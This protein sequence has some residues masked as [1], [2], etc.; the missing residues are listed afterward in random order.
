MPDSPEILPA[1][2]RTELADLGKRVETLGRWLQELAEGGESPWRG[3]SPLPP[4]VLTRCAL[5]DLRQMLA[6]SAWHC[7]REWK[8]LMKETR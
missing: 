5:A 1:A 6:E 2:T 3:S 4:A 8:R 7:E